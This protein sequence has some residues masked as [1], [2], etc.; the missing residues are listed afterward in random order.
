MLSK[1]EFLTFLFAGKLDL[2]VTWTVKP[3]SGTTWKLGT[4]GYIKTVKETNGK[5][6]LQTRDTDVAV[7]FET[8]SVKLNGKKIGV[9]SLN[10]FESMCICVF[11]LL[12]LCICCVEGV[13]G[14]GDAM[15]IYGLFGSSK[16]YSTLA[17]F[18][19]AALQNTC[20]SSDGCWTRYKWEFLE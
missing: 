9:V 11:F 15:T 10:I 4:Y 13:N 6:Y 14:L 18:S 8:P 5:V 17:T 7:L 1:Y 12:F 3:A 20:T 16:T 19:G 2:S